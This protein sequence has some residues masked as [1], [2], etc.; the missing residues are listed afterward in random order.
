MVKTPPIGGN[1]EREQK[2]GLKATIP[3]SIL[4]LLGINAIIGTGIFF[5]PG[6]AAQLAGP[7]SLI[8]WTLVAIIALIIA[9]CFAELSS[10]FPKSGGVYE[11]TKQGFG[12]FAGFMVGWTSWI[13]ANITIAMLAIGALDYFG[14]II[15]VSYIQRLIIAIIFVVGMN[16]VS[17]RGIDMSVKVLL[18]F[19]VCTILSLWTLL[20]W[21]VYYVSASNLM[22]LSIFPKVSIVIAM[23]YILET[24]F[25]WETVTYLAEE[26]KDPAKTIPK[27]MM[28]GTAAV[29]LLA[30]GVVAV[31]LGAVN[32]EVLANSATPLLEAANIF[33]G[34]SGARLIAVLVFLNILGGAAAWI[35]V[36]PRLIFALGRD[37]LLPDV[38]SRIHPV[39]QTPY[40][41]IAVQTVLT[42][43]IL[44]SGSYKLL[45][46]MILPLAIFMYSMVIVSVTILRFTKP[47]LERPFKIPFGKILPI[48]TAM[49]LLFL[50]GGIEFQTT[51]SGVMFVMIGIPLFLLEA[52]LY[53][54]KLVKKILSLSVGITSRTTDFWL[55][56]KTRRYIKYHIGDIKGKNVMNF[57][58]DVSKFTVELSKLIGDS[59]KLCV[60]H[61]SKDHIDATKELAEKHKLNNMIYYVE[62]E[63]RHVIHP[64]L[65]DFDAIV[66]V[67]VLGYIQ[68]PHKVIATLGKRVKKGG[69]IY[70][71][72]YT[73][74]LKIMPEQKWLHDVEG[75]KRMFAQAGFKVNVSRHKGLL[76][77]TI[78]ICGKKV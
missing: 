68:D 78:H 5:V 41:A 21:G 10:M 59:G 72:D 35:V 16:F 1:R 51:I 11:Y 32:W 52:M 25:G 77:N 69:K 15:E 6:I 17:Y 75:I 28:W 22:P 18:F 49:I 43:I 39:H 76:W 8:S 3:F 36:T 44:L 46:E 38:L 13:V 4:L 74:L 67:G 42:I 27:V 33:M 14:A 73:N 55:T 34:Q 30:L 7:G 20:T 19:A 70:F 56:R 71:V 37:K 24:F 47:H 48:I 53:K 40:Y 50:A 26:T 45:L 63:A 60:T 61:A 57:G 12:E 58:T 31:T 62:N 29:V 64:K 66:S 23:L 9:A 65:K 54:P 2:T